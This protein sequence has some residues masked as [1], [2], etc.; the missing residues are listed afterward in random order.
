[1]EAICG[2]KRY[3]VESYDFDVINLIKNK[4]FNIK[5]LFS[6]NLINLLFHQYVW[7]PIVLRAFNPKKHWLVIVLI[8]CYI[9]SDESIW[10]IIKDYKINSISHSI[11]HQD[12]IYNRLSLV[13]WFNFWCLFIIIIL[14][15]VYIFIVFIYC[16]YLLYLSY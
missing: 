5:Y 3:F 8:W 12:R 11:S 7:N 2:S 9:Y 4:Y 16:I 10:K 1:M 15:R 14:C 13:C 6:A